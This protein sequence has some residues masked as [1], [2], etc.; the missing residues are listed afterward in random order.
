MHRLRLLFVSLALTGPLLAPQSEAAEA[1]P[2]DA[3]L[4]TGIDLSDSIMRHEEWLQFEGIA[5]AVEDPVFLSA[6]TSG[7]YR[8]VSFAVFT[9]SSHGRHRLIVP[10]T[11]IDGADGARVAATM[12]RAAPRPARFGSGVMSERA[13]RPLER[14]TDLSGAIRFGAALLAAGPGAGARKILNIISNGVD[15]VAGG[16]AL[17]RERAVAAGI[18]INGVVLGRDRK[19]A[20]YFRAR[21]IGGAGSFV[22]QVAEPAGL[23]DVL[24]TKFLRDLI[25]RAGRD[26]WAPA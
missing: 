20:E 19:L 6:A 26:G 24:R 18:T 23:V 9:W 12:I 17:A 1:V 3:A 13:E 5:R 25:A 2:V 21:V 7:P 8:R 16:V 14:Q 10:W 11:V 4:A 22:M 15:N